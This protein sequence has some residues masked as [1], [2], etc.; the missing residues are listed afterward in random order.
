VDFDDLVLAKTD[1]EAPQPMA[2]CVFD[3]G[4]IAHLWCILCMLY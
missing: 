3:S 4:C 1:D 2:L